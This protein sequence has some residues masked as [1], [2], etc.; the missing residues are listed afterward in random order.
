VPG[1]RAAIGGSAV[2]GARVVGL[3]G[4]I[5]VA[6]VFV[7]Q[8]NP[9]NAELFAVVYLLKGGGDFSCATLLATTIDPI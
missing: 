9:I 5:V 8:G 3:H 4:F 2:E 7:D 1:H 6:I